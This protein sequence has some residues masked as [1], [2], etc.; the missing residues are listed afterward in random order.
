MM[1]EFKEPMMKD[2]DMLD[3]GNMR[4]FIGIDVVQFDGDI[5]ISQMNYVIEMLR[6][7][8]M[9]HDNYVENPKV[10]KFKIS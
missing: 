8:G 4:H 10:P 2:F 7:F 5:F 3:F 6:N 9:E 1:Y